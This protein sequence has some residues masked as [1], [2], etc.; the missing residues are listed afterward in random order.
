MLAFERASAL[1]TSIA[2]RFITVTILRRRHEVTSG[3]RVTRNA[4][5]SSRVSPRISA[6]A[7]W[8]FCRESETSPGLDIA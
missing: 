2:D 4:N 7:A 3:D 5:K 8:T 6:R 1:P